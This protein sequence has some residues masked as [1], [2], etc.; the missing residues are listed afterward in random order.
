MLDTPK[1]DEAKLE[2]FAT[3]A[4]GDLTAGYTGV[5]VSVGSKLG[6]YK[7]MAGAG[8]LSA[9][10]IATLADCAE[11]YVSEWLNAQAAGG[12]LAYHAL[13]DTYELMPEQAMVLADED[14][15][16][17]IPHAWNVPASMWFDEPKTLEAFRTGKGI[18]WGERDGRLSC[19]S[20][21]FYRNGYR[22]SLVPQWLPA[23]DG[24]VEQLEGGIEVADVGCGYGHSTLLMAEA[25]PNSRFHGFDTHDATLAEGRQNAAA[26]GLSNRIDF[27]HARADEY[28]D[29][30][31]GLICFFDILHDLGDPVAAARHAA[32]VLAPGGTVLLVEPFAHDHVKDNLSPVAQ[33]YY[34][35][36]TLVCCAHA[37]SEG[38]TMVLGAQ[39]GQARLAEVFR[40]AGFTH[41]RRAAETPFNLI[42]E[43][44]R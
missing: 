14:S 29:G 7:A 27:A 34:S 17:Y 39:A 38:G 42:F 35:A 30:R 32:K 25:F 8:P 2:A 11:R 43:V 41:F 21:A 12:Y 10:E 26:A 5:M 18:A 3:R 36:S 44:R 13:S 31:Y 28:P 24:V 1:I 4:I 33:L 9:Q 19:G 16:V 20:A 37:I 22:A 15:P 6:L 23:L 40:K